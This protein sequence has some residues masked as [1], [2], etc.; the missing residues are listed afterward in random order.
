MLT[1]RKPNMS[2]MMSWGQR[3]GTHIKRDTMGTHPK[4][5]VGI[6]IKYDVERK[7]YIVYYKKSRKVITMQHVRIIN[8]SPRT[9]TTK[10][11]ETRDA[12]NEGVS[13]RTITIG[14]AIDGTRDAADDEYEK[15]IWNVQVLPIQ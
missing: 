9:H 8:R 13:V 12:E 1:G 14:E 6:V 11:H 5:E 2:T 10:S 3:V 15:L 4:G 7:V